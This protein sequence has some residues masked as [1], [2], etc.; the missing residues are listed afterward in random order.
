MS[1][2]VPAGTSGQRLH[3]EMY[4]AGSLHTRTLKLGK[5]SPFRFT[6]GRSG[7]VSIPPPFNLSQSACF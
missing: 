1:L 6:E 2:V 7:H 3:F 4:L 5:Y